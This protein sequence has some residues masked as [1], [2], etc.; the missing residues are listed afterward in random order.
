M[1]GLLLRDLPAADVPDG[2][3]PAGCG[4]GRLGNRAGAVADR[5]AHQPAQGPALVLVGLRRARTGPGR[6]RCRAA[7]GRQGW[8]RGRGQRR[9]P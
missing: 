8:R 5:A 1:D 6:G 9:G 7:R 4:R 3:L 2:A